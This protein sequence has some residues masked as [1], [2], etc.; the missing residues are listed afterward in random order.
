MELSDEAVIAASNS[1]IWVPDNATATE[2][3]EYLIVRFP[4]YFDHPLEV[5]RFTPTGPAADMVEVV[6]DR[7]REYGLPKLWWMVR[8]DSPSGVRELLEA[9]GATL[10]E[11]LDVLAR[12]LS[13]GAAELPPPAGAAE[14]RWAVDP[15]TI[16]DGLAVGAEVFGVARLWFGAVVEAARGQGFYWAVLAARLAYAARHGATMALVKG[17]IETSG[18]ILRRAG[19]AAYGQELIYAVSLA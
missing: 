2:T 11:T 10:D 14:L 15:A 19:F 16:R 4:D 9:R 17:R 3:D 5:V 6:L 7:A 12:D 18:S 1:W 13:G 8:L